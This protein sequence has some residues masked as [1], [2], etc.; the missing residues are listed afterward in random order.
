MTVDGPVRRLK[1][2]IHHF[3]YDGIVDQISTLNRF[4]T[5]TAETKYAEGQRCH[6]HDLLFRPMIRFVRGYLL[7]R[8]FMDGLPG[9]IISMTTAY[10]VLIKYSKLWEIDMRSRRKR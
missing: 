7:R 9:F 6:V 4:S 3:T 1:S 2:P 8:G 5:I 10:G